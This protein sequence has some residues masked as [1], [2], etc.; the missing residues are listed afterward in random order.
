M[1]KHLVVFS[2]GFGVD[3]TDRGLFADIAAGLGDQIEP[4]MFDYNQIDK[5][6]NTMTVRPFSEQIELFNEEYR[7]ASSANPD[8][9]PV[10]I[11]HSQGCLIASMALPPAKKVIMLAP[12]PSLSIDRL[13]ENFSDRP[14]VEINLDGVSRLT[15]RDGSSTLIGAEYV[16]E[17]RA[18]RPVQAFNRLAKQTEVVMVKA[19]ADEVLGDVSYEGIEGITIREIPGANHDFTG[20]ARAKLIEL[21]KKEL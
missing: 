9:I 12:A 3:K 6:S 14:G 7:K 5:S 10:V 19:G 4:W 18:A 11:G 15:R 21:L 2:H 1:A 17:M 20:P 16:K 8:L 13:V